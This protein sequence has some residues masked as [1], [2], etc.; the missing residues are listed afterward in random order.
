[1]Q[2]QKL[3]QD[4]PSIPPY[5]Y[6][7]DPYVGLSKQQIIDLRQQYVNPVVATYYQQPIMIVEGSMQYVFDETGKRYLDGF[8]GIATINLGHCHPHVVKA[9]QEQSA[10]LQH[11]TTLYLHPTIAEYSKMLVDKI[12]H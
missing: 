5:D 1:M 12:N 6:Q 2:N 4:R 7:P 8:A 3:S 11:T 10:K 9:V